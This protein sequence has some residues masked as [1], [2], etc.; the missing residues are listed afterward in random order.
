MNYYGRRRYYFRRY[1]FR[2]PYRRAYFITSRSQR[3]ASRN[4]RAA[5]SQ[6]DTCEVNLSIP[7]TVSAFNSQITIGDNQEIAFD[8]G[9]GI[10]NIWDLM[11]K[12]EFYQ[13]YANM[14]D[15]VKINKVTVKLTPYQFPIFTNAQNAVQNYYNS[16]TIITAW[17]RT[18]LSD[19]QMELISL[20]ST[21]VIGTANNTDG[22]YI[23][24]SPSVAATYSSALTKNVNPNSSS[25]IVRYL[26]P[27]T[28]AEKGYY[29]NTA[30][31]DSWYQG[32]TDNTNRYYGID[33]PRNVSGG[34]AVIEDGMEERPAAIYP[35]SLGESR[36]IT[37]NP[38]YFGESPEVPFKPTLLVGCLNE[39]TNI[40]I[41]PNDNIE[42]IP[43]MKFQV[44]CD[45][46]VTFRGLRKA[47][48]VA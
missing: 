47:T 12:S 44:E 10:I 45:V 21:N 48:I 33:N 5:M 42:L 34:V 1:G 35:L 18:G 31:I 39:K 23:A 40:N 9:V 43:R 15:Q 17:D 27:S 37:R 29:V 26:Y 30:D 19:E 22:L 16:Y 46:V 41:G 2:R 25:S 20:N 3:R 14:Y 28:I 13:S 38:C 11:R 24:M 36:A 32:K 6:K 4:Q 8:S 7:T